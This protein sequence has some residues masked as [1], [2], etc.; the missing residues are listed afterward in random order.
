[1]GCSILPSVLIFSLSQIFHF[2]TLHK[3]L[4]GYSLTVDI[5][6]NIDKYFTFGTMLV[7]I[8]T[9]VSLI[10]AILFI[11]LLFKIDAFKNKC[12]YLDFLVVKD[13]KDKIYI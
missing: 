6:I 4:T 5:L 7:P 11:C 2:C 8:Q 12:V 3:T 13:K 9:I 1:M 10:G